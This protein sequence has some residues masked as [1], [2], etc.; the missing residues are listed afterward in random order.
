MPADPDDMR[1]DGRVAVVTGAGRGLGREYA[2]MLASRGAKVVVNDGGSTFGEGRA[3]A[4]AQSVVDAIRASGGEAVAS[5]DCGW[6]EDRERRWTLGRIDIVVNNAGILRDKSFAKMTEEDWDLVYRVHLKGTYKVC[7]AAWPLCA[8]SGTVESSTSPPLRGS[9]ETLARPITG[10]EAG[11]RRSEQDACEGGARR[12]IFTN[13]IAPIG[14]SMT[15]PFCPTTSFKPCAQSSSPP[16]VAF[17]AH[18]ACEV[19]GE[20]STRRRVGRGGPMAAQPG[21]L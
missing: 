18:E 9:T 3:T 5:F 14:G 20:P 8:S 19:N 6:R 17:L 2:L 21:R 1:F 16:W 13:V 4:P 11:Y 7:A 12:N 15:L 10:D